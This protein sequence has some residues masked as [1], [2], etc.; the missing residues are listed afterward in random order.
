MTHAE[1]VARAARWLKAQG[2][3]T[4]VAEKLPVTGFEEPDAIGWWSFGRSLLVECKASR[5]D[6]LRDAEKPHRR[7]PALGMG[8]RRVYMTPPGVVHEGELPTGWGLVEVSGRT[9]KVTAQPTDRMDWNRHAELCLL[10]AH[11]RRVEG[12]SK[13]MRKEK[14]APCSPLSPL[15]SSA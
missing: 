1:L 4:I 7:F 3:G 9:A 5:A 14:A 13:R 10:L 2:C 6:S 15:P 8:V 12:V 11:I